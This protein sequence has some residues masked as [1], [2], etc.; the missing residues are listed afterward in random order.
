M[1]EMHGSGM[2]IFKSMDT[3]EGPMEHNKMHGGSVSLSI[4]YQHTIGNVAANNKMHSGSQCRVIRARA[5]CRCKRQHS[6]GQGS[7]SRCRRQCNRRQGNEPCIISMGGC[8]TA[9]E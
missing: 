5:R 4:Q 3:Y 9:A 6:R 7:I 2:L 1:G 8:V